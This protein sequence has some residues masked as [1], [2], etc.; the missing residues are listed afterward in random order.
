[1]SVSVRKDINIPKVLTI[2]ETAS[3]MRCSKRHVQ[4]LMY[5]GILKYY[6]PTPRRVLIDLESVEAL[7]A[8]PANAAVLKDSAK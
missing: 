8:V 6:K 5:S 3:L 1:M 2:A 7:F 4:H